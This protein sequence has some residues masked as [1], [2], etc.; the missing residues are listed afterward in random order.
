[1]GELPAESSNTPHPHGNLSPPPLLPAATPP[2]YHRCRP[3]QSCSLALVVAEEVSLLSAI[4]AGAA[5]A[6]GLQCGALA[7]AAVANAPRWLV[8]H[9]YL[10]VLEL[11]PGLVLSNWPGDGD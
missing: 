1:M 5:P 4:I 3:R 7:L 6:V 11:G 10:H 2:F 9:I 8:H